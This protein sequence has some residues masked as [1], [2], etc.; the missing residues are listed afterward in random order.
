MP[1]VTFV[2]LEY[3]LEIKRSGSLSAAAKTMRV[4]QPAVSYALA[5]LELELGG[6]QLVQRS[7]RGSVLTAA[8][9]E[10]ADDA[11]DILRR[12]EVAT[13]R[14]RKL[15]G[16]RAGRV[17]IG[18]TP[19][20]SNLLRESV[21]QILADLAPELRIV[22]A[23]GFSGQLRDMVA[24]DRLD[25][26]LLY[27]VQPEDKNIRAKHLAY[28]PMFLMTGSHFVPVSRS[29]QCI[30]LRMLSDIELVIPTLP[31]EVMARTLTSIC[32]QAGV[33]LNVKYQAQSLSMVRA[34]LAR[35]SIGTVYPL[36]VL[37]DDV[38]SRH[39]NAW[40]IIEPAVLREVCFA[41]SST[42][43]TTPAIDSI[44]SA[45]NKIAST[46]L[47]PSGLWKTEATD[48][49]PVHADMLFAIQQ[50]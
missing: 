24:E 10:F 5:Q 30:P 47:I 17:A 45:I 36:G 32:T 3:L 14:T 13:S 12:L 46:T 18:M 49:A 44:L 33:N 35:Q 31:D 19:G 40:Q 21:R 8:G 50:R 27:D 22:F 4:A 2:Q 42:K 25:C 15:V 29:K 6:V 34:L 23:E 28:E 16:G 48:T 41:V 39:V 38:L 20:L 1:N 11:Q 43:N 9:A 7:S 26:A 37:L